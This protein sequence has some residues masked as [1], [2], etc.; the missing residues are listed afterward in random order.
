MTS[1]SLSLKNFSVYLSPVSVRGSPHDAADLVD[2]INLGGA[3][4]ERSPGV[5]LGHDA[6]HGPQINGAGVGG[7]AEQDLGCSV[8]ASADIVS[9]GGRGAD[10]SRQ[11]KVSNLDHVW[12]GAEN[13]LWLEISV[14]ESVTMHI[15]QGLEDLEDDGPDR[16]LA[17]Q[18][19]AVPHQTQ[20]VTLHILEYEVETIVLPDDLLQLDNIRMIELLET[21]DF[22]EIH[23]FRPAVIFPLHRLDCH[24]LPR[25]LNIKKLT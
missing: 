4:E 5:E 9:V 12:R 22:S 18:I 19:L 13:V 11:T 23:H 1:H 3:G 20:Q 17:Q 15:G 10:L 14:E 8:P 21:L 24:L 25:L 2:L 6:S 7:G 16:G